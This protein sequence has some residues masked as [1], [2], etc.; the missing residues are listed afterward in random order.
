MNLQ[1]EIAKTAYEL[2]KNSGCVE[3]RDFENWLEAERLVL[4]V[5]A[6]PELVQ[7]EEVR[8]SEGS[9]DI[10]LVWGDVNT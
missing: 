7:N 6:G 9:Q 2:Y 4:A 5:R 1:E 10:L 3:G 8:N